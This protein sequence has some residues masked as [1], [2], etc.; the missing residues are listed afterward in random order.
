MI[1]P[2][3][4]AAGFADWLCH[5][6]A[7]IELSAGPRESAL[8]LLM[9]AEAAIAVLAALFLQVNAG[10]IA[11]IIAALIVHQLTAMADVRY[12]NA[13][14][15]ISPNEQHV[16]SF[17][18]SL[19][20]MAALLVFILHWPQLLSLFGLGAEPAD[21]SIRAKDPPLNPIYLAALLTAIA[22]VEVL[23]YA[24]EFWRGVRARRARGREGPLSHHSKRSFRW[25]ME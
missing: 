19:P 20:F 21:L 16:H 15:S 9:L 4:V 23:L 6:A 25:L 2:L 24:E 13:V 3:W 5:R 14:R 7:R 12:A 10:V 17:L 8:H 11:L 22:L 18:E 1:V